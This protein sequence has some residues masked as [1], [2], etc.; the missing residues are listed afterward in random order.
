MPIFDRI[1]TRVGAS[2]DLSRGQSTFMVEMSEAAEILR[3]A[4]CHSLIILDE[5]GRGTST[6]DGL[7]IAAAIL[8]D[9]ADRVGCFTMFATHYH[10]LVPMM[11][12]RKSIVPMQTEVVEKNGGI[13]FSHRLVAGACA[14]SFG[15]EVAK[16]AGIPSP[17]IE[18][19]KAHLQCADLPTVRS[20]PSHS[21]A[22]ATVKD[23][24]PAKA[25]SRVQKGLFGLSND[26]E[27]IAEGAG[28]I[29]D[30]AISRMV[31]RLEGVKIHKTTPLQAL[32]ILNELKAMLVPVQHRALFDDDSIHP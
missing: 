11:A 25:L 24:S 29:T 14:S 1:F 8:E 10:E 5:V 12:S 18:L 16:L 13:V 30:Q 4:T 7:A 2:D 23:A 28:L 9:L 26:E 17:V 19:A 27:L 21:L 6:T 31:S 20:N 15:I 32:N 22:G 3:Q